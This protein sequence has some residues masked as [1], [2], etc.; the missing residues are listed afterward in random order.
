[1][2][3]KTIE[4]LPQG[5]GRCRKVHIVATLVTTDGY[6]YSSSNYCMS[7]QETCPRNE[8]GMKAGEGYELCK[9]ICKQDGHAEQ[10]VIDFVNSTTWAGVEG[11][12]IF[13]EHDWI[14]DG[15]KRTAKYAGVKEL[16]LGEPK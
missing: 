13:V 7:P 9:S 5:A 6:R 11:S 2:K 8:R 12:T 16:V 14:C 4:W 15:C 1:M 10:N 3:N